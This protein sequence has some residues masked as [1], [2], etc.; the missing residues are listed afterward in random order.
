MAPTLRGGTDGV[1]HIPLAG[2][3][4]GSAKRPFNPLGEAAGRDLED[5]HRFERSA[6]TLALRARERVA[7]RS[8]GAAFQGL[9]PLATSGLQGWFG[10]AGRFSVGRSNGRNPEPEL[11]PARGA[12]GSR[13][14]M[15]DGLGRPHPAEPSCCQAQS[16]GR[17]LKAAATFW[18]C[19]SGANRRSV[20]RRWS[21]RVGVRSRYGRLHAP[22][23]GTTDS[24]STKRP[25]D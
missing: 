9:K 23:R 21:R 13:P 15:R 18:R 24:A 3:F 14:P 7:I 4:A 5:G 20:L 11:C 19:S 6:R 22:H 2:G 25:G 17:S 1:E 10:R 8:W 12:R 16:V